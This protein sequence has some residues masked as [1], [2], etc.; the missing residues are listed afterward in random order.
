MQTDAKISEGSSGGPLFDGSG[1]V[2]GIM[3]Y[4][5]IRSDMGSGDNFAFAI[6][7]GVVKDAINGLQGD[8]ARFTF[9]HGRYHHEMTQ[10]FS[11][12]GSSKCSQALVSFENA[13]R[14]INENFSVVQNVQPYI[15]QCQAMIAQ[16]KSIDSQWDKTK[17]LLGLIG[18][19]SWAGVGI[20]LLVIVIISFKLFSMKRLLK[21]DE[22]EMRLMEH[23][24]EHM[25]RRELEESRQLRKLERR[26]DAIK[27]KRRIV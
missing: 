3:A 25:A 20:A 26:I 23:D 19:R 24:L 16:G 4:Q 2:I 5:S 27:K 18:W 1:K 15:E 14:D 13:I 10:G 22:R 12:F 7:I 8:S 17:Q 11:F 21:E 9:E 6:P